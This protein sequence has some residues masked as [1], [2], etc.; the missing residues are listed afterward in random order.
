MSTLN[1]LKLE[2]DALRFVEY[3]NM[4]PWT[5]SSLKVENGNTQSTHI[6][7]KTTQAISQDTKC[8]KPYRKS[9]APW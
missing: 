5:S 2:R 1:A 8:I 3:T 4:K 6:Y 9:V 7:S